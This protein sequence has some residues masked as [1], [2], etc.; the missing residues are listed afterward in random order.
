MAKV[1]DPK[2]LPNAAEVEKSPY[3]AHISKQAKQAVEFLGDPLEAS[4][5]LCRALVASEPVEI[6][7]SRL[8]HLDDVGGSMA[9]LVDET[10]R[11]HK[12]AKQNAV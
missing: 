12:Q 2:F 6:L 5:L 8:Q 1:L 7:S 9:E 4:L 3:H 11:E 10:G